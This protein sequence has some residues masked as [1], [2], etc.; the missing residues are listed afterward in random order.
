[1]GNLER[2]KWWKL[3]FCDDL[4]KHIVL[5]SLEAFDREQFIQKLKYSMMNF[6]KKD[7]LLFIHG[8]NTSF[9]DAILRTAQI[10]YDL[11]FLGPALLYSW[12][13]EAKFDKYVT[14]ENNIEWTIPHLEEFLELLMI[15]VDARTVNAIAHSMGNRALVRAINS[16]NLSD[17]NKHAAILKHIVFAAPDVDADT[18]RQFAKA[19]RTKAERF[20]LYA[21]SKDKALEVSKLVHGG[22]PRAGD[23]G[24]EL[25][26]VDGVD[27]I[28]ASQVDTSL[29]GHSYIGDNRSI[30]S[31]I[32]Y[33]LR[34]DFHPDQRSS[35]I[36]QSMGDFIYW[37]FHA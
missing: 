28:D 6:I 30:L 4:R 17:V 19:F 24:K 3:K 15:A 5:L 20:T 22:Y 29:I 33:L 36:S 37:L 1:M 27:T 18:F 2:P 32:F 26:I 7:L 10:A 35:L 11:H 16:L 23:S 21:S 13:S 14:D 12:P 9:E 34:H 8:Y 31:D 25:V